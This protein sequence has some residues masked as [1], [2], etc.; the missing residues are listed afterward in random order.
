[1]RNEITDLVYKDPNGDPIGDPID[2]F[3]GIIDTM[4]EK[5]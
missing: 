2:F 4:I 5:V 1:M 3:K